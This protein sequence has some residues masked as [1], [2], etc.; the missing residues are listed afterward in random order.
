MSFGI[1]LCSCFGLFSTQHAHWWKENRTVSIA[2]PLPSSTSSSLSISS[3]S[4]FSSL[5]Y[6][7]VSPA[8]VL[9]LPRT[10]TLYRFNSD[11]GFPRPESAVQDME[12][13]DAAARSVSAASAC[14]PSFSH[15]SGSGKLVSLDRT[16][17]QI[18]HG[19][20][21]E[22]HACMLGRMFHSSHHCTALRS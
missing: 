14:F 2:L 17:P 7:P 1:L 19:L 6:P 11:L 21:A 13:L 3:S 8:P 22:L 4:S 12:V 16:D 18:R 9:V 10:C 5:A 15:H 20:F